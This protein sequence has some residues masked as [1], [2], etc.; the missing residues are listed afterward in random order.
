MY[1]FTLLL[2]LLVCL[3]MSQPEVCRLFLAGRCAW[4]DKCH[5]SHNA[6]GVTPQD[7]APVA[8]AS[9]RPERAEGNGIQPQLTVSPGVRIVD[10]TYTDRF[11]RIHR[12]DDNQPAESI[13]ATV[14]A[15]PAG[16]TTPKPRRA[17]S[18]RRPNAPVTQPQPPPILPNPPLDDEQYPENLDA[19]RLSRA[20]ELDPRPGRVSEFFRH[21]K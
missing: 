13:V 11:H 1:T 15:V 8:L 14:A 18:D 21:C 7:V 10:G 20:A 16:S 12:L 17:P 5:R 6:G 2:T 9:N 3:Q 19:Q 4:G